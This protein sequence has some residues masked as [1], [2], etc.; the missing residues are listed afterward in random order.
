[1][2]ARTDVPPAPQR[3]VVV[4]SHPGWH[5][6][7]ELAIGPLAAVA[8]A[9]IARVGHAMPLAPTRGT[10]LRTHELAEDAPLD[11]PDLTGPVARLTLLRTFRGFRSRAG[12][13]AARLED[14]QSHLL[15]HP[16]CDFLEG[17]T[18]PDPRILAP[19]DG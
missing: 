8:V 11:T 3:D 18:Q 9:L 10:G 15:R 19:L 4:R 12:A 13:F 16:R 2:A 5:L 1:T 17:H 14:R 7:L 6:D